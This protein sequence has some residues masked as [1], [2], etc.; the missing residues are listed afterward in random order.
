MLPEMGIGQLIEKASYL[1]PEKAAFVKE[2]YHF[3]AKSHMGQVCCSGAPYIQHPLHVALTL[4][5]LGQDAESLGA[6]LLH[7]VP[8]KCGVPENIIEAR[9]GQQA[10]RLVNGV[11]RIG[12]MSW[13][14]NDSTRRDSK[15]KNSS[16]ILVAMAEDIRVIYI[17][18]A[19]RLNNLQMLH[20]M[21]PE[22]KSSIAREAMDIFAPA[23]GRL[24]IRELEWQLEDY[25]FRILEPDKYRQIAQWLGIRRLQR[26]NC[27]FQVVRELEEEF[28]KAGLKAEISGYLKNIFN[29]YRKLHKYEKSGKELKDIHNLVTVQVLVETVIDCYKA[30]DSVHRLWHTLPQEFDDHIANPKSNG[31]RSL[32]T[33]VMYMGNTPLEIH[34]RTYDMQRIAEYGTAAH[35]R[36]KEAERKEYPLK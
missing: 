25:S 10:N 17:I 2:A 23:A 19:D 4:A 32:H 14:V 15:G 12:K 9:F 26:E 3:A 34:I 28:S 30:L 31:Y 5:H 35:W 29:I 22:E 13:T 11:V 20:F 33:A 21:P 36:Y 8:M 6:A 16:K 24:G 27:L 1:S 7:D 18:L